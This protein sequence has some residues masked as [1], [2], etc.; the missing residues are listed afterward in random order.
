M[1]IQFSP[2]AFDDLDGI[3]AHYK[4]EGVPQVGK[5]ILAA[6]IE[7]IQTLCDFPDIGRSVPEYNEVQIR[8]LIHPP[9][10][11]VYLREP[12]AVVIIRVL[13]SERL[14]VLPDS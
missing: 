10:R 12:K 9:F 1:K 8:E 4:E 6:I 5:K 11:I 14:L 3:K 7:H 13:R 2:S